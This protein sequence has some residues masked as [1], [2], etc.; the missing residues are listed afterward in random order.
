MEWEKGIEGEKARE[1]VGGGGV[2]YIVE[3]AM[4]NQWRS[5]DSSKNLEGG[6]IIFKHTLYIFDN[7]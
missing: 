4:A 5:I 1:R 3:L 6:D 7:N 2:V